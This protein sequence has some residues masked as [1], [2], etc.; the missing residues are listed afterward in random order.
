MGGA[1]RELIN[2]GQRYSIYDLRNFCD[3]T[4]VNPDGRKRLPSR[5]REA[6]N[7]PD[8]AP[9]LQTSETAAAT[10]APVTR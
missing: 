10:D 5:K 3:L 1:M 4:G 8:T 9:D 6:A 7:L 2:F